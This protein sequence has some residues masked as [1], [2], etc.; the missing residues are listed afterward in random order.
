MYSRPTAFGPPVSG[1]PTGSNAS[2]ISVTKAQPMDGIAGFNWA[3]TPPYYHGESWVDIIFEPERKKTYDLEKILAEIRTVYWR[4]DPGISASVGTAY[5]TQLIPT[6]SASTIFPAEND[7]IY[8]GKNVNFNAMQL[9]ASVNFLGIERIAK[10]QKDKFGNEILTEN[11]T[12]GKQWIIEPKWE[13]PMLNFNDGGVRPITDADSTL[14][15]PTFG[16][17]SVPR[18]MWH[19]FGIIPETSDKGIFLEIGEI[20]NSWL[21]NHYSVI[22]NDSIYNNENAAVSGAN[23]YTRMKPLTDVVNFQPEKAKAR[24]GELSDK[25]VIKEGVVAIPYIIDGAATGETVSGV[26]AQQRKRFISIPQQRIDAAKTD[27]IGSAVGDS[28][29]T[30]GE[31]IRKLVQK[32]ERYVL[33]PQFDFLNNPDV[34]PIA[35]YIFEFSYTLDRNDL[36]YIWQNLAPRDYKKITLTF[37]S[38]AHKLGDNEI[39]S[40]SNLMDNENLR[41]MV[42]KVKQKS[43]SNYS[44]LLTSQVGQSSN[45]D[46]F[47]SNNGN[48]GYDICF[49][50]P[51][52]YLSFV[53]LIKVDAEVLYGK[54]D[55]GNSN[56]NPNGNSG[57]GSSGTGMY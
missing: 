47:D 45:G 48:N 10:Q 55:N 30:A 54:S 43:Q 9:S 40:E 19:Q 4:V 2:H 41:W 49:N 42:F 33:P 28:L 13:T 5:N 44:K 17:A 18:G 8:D 14:S 24:L 16:S 36:S 15:V 57:T 51:Y 27:A 29:D 31:S 12:A 39:L 1:R 53:E 11:E 22:T 50:W 32:M 56:G 26:Q 21:K 37:D 35:M 52:D 6:F 34:D 23:L 25:K 20:P 46:L 7:Q 3:Y 38:I